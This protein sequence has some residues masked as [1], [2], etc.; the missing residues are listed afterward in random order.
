MRSI[1][2]SPPVQSSHLQPRYP[3]QCSQNSAPAKGEMGSVESRT[4]QPTVCVYRPR[5]KGMKRW[6][7][8]QKASKHCWRMRW[9][10]V[11]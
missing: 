11:V 5:K 10:A 9:C 6:C 8:Y 2:Y 4:K 3:I 7:V 1:R